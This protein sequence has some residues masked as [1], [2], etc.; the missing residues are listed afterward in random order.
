MFAI[1]DI[2]SVKNLASI[3]V[4]PFFAAAFIAG[5]G[6]NTFN[7]PVTGWLTASSYLPFKIIGYSLLLASVVALTTLTFAIVDYCVIWIH[8]TLNSAYP[9]AIFGFTSLTAGLFVLSFAVP[10][11]PKSPLNPFWH[12]GFLCYGFS[13]L[14][15]GENR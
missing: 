10:G 7:D 8:V 2:E 5:G 3:L 11:L 6:L 15:R 12:F 1:K 14:S 9:M 4:I 13:L